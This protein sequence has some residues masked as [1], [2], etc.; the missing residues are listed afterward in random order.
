MPAV[1]L[2]GVSN[3]Q[4]FTD[5]G[6]LAAGYR[7]YT[8]AAGTTTHKVAYTDAAGTTSQTYVSDG[9]GGLYIAL[10]ARGELPAPLFLASGAYD[11]ALKTTAGASVWT[12]YAMGGDAPAD[13]LR[14]DLASTAT[15]KGDALIG[16]KSV[17]AGSV[18]R[19]QHDKNAEFVSVLD[20]GANTTPGTT[21][22]T[23]AIQA[24]IDAVGELGTVYFPPGTYKI[25]D[26][27]DIIYTATW[28][29][30]NLLGSGVASKLVWDGGNNKPMIWVRGSGSGFGWYSKGFIEKLYLYGESFTGDT[31]SG[32]TG[33]RVGVGNTVGDAPTGACN[34]TVRDNI[35][36]HC[37]IGVMGF[38]ESDEFTVENNYIERFTQYG[39]Y[40]DF[41]GSGWNIIGNHISDGGSSS[42]GVR[43]S[44]SVSK[45]TGNV[46]QGSQILVGVQVDGGTVKQGKCAE[47]T[48]NYFESQLAG[49]YGVIFYGVQTGVIKNNTF[50]GFAGATLI[51][52]Q[53]VSGVSCLG[54]EIGTNRHTQS[55]GLISA[56]VAA[57]SGTTNCTISGKQYTDGSV[58]T[59][60]GP[61][62]FK[63]ADNVL[64][65]AS[66]VGF[67]ATQVAS[68]DANT[69]D[70]YQEGTFTPGF[71]FGATAQTVVSAATY[72]K[73]GNRV[74]ASGYVAM[75]AAVAGTGSA[76]ITGLPFT[77][78]A[79][80][81][82]GVAPAAISVSNLTYTGTPS[83][84]VG[85]SA[86]TIALFGT[87]EA[88][89][90]SDLTHANF[91][92]NSEVYFSVT[93][94]VA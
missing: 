56:L 15:G 92:A 55:G 77:S 22:M 17:L 26:T 60:T 86:T 8:Y 32:V 81:A 76:L 50:N 75:G 7:L 52:L 84:A 90:R 85:A 2:S 78:A 79:L 72:T 37:A 70:D 42:T 35:I 69:L 93:Y 43:S 28:R 65:V 62:G 91:A 53:D 89:A 27:L 66:G 80:A 63:Y 64:S 16:V 54:V 46:I 44:L 1:S 40:N 33:I 34:F 4:Q 24:A 6:L 38:Y 73:V 36:S 83:A 39:V 9:I 30:V 61:F 67:P 23:S 88:G 45:I 51:A 48:S 49:G 57:T 25:T 10:D 31:Y 59:I 41:G 29:A 19:T 58:D 3:L 82:G 11:I 74:S 18:A 13:A 68:S 20:F 94:P 21:D 71:S 87:T 12:R 14:A 5:A 47:V